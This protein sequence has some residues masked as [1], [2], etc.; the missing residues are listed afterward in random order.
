MT[1]LEQPTGEDLSNFLDFSLNSIFSWDSWLKGCTFSC[2][3]SARVRMCFKKLQWGSIGKKTSKTKNQFQEWSSSTNAP[4]SHQR[5]IKD[6]RK[7][8]RWN[9]LQHTVLFVGVLTTDYISGHSS[10]VILASFQIYSKLKKKKKTKMKYFVDAVITYKVRSNH[11]RCSVK[12]M[13]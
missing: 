13:F 11:Q 9:A 1:S 5:R 3:I 4:N 7:H 6:P 10:I 8:V 2:I 12:K